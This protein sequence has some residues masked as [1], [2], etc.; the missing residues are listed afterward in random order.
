MRHTFNA[1]QATTLPIAGS[2]ERVRLFLGDPRH[3]VEALLDA[4]RV[5]QL[6]AGRFVV[7]MSPIQALN[8]QITPEVELEIVT[9]RQSRV[10][11]KAVGCRIHGNNWIDR[12]FDLSFEGCLFP[13]G[14]ETTDGV[15]LVGD[16]NLEVSIG[17]PP[18]LQFTPKSIVE[19]IGNTITKGVLTA[20]D[21]SLRRKLP[22]RFQQW[23]Q[24]QY[25][26]EEIAELSAERSSMHQQPI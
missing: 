7:R 1:R 22:A 6:E 17:M 11:L 9:D 25:L 18:L 2:P 3:L 16:A 12:N 19:G 15:E 20:I 4:D 14:M 13:R 26:T 24:E 10:L 21:R 5:R 23:Q 8:V